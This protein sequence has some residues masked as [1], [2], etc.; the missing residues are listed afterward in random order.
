MQLSNLRLGIFT[1]TDPASALAML[2]SWL[3]FGFLESAF[4]ER[5]PSRYFVFDADT[6]GSR[7]LSTAYIRRYY[8]QWH[9]GFLELPDDKK[10]SLAQSI[11]MPRDWMLFLSVKLG[12]RTPEYNA[13]PLSTAFNATVRTTVLL[14]E[15]L[16]KA[17]PQGFSKVEFIHQQIDLDPGDYIYSRMTERKWCPSS[18]RVLM[19]KYGP[20]VA[21]YATLLEPAENSSVSH[22]GCDRETCVAYNVDVSTYKPR[23]LHE[24][25]SCENIGPP[26]NDVYRALQSGQ[27]PLLDGEGLIYDSPDGQLLVKCYEPGTEFVAVS[28]VWSDG[29]GS[30][31]ENGLPRC[32]VAYLSKLTK[33]ISGS[34]LFWIDGL[35]VP[36]DTNTRIAAIHKMAST[37]GSASI[38]LVLDA[39]IRKCSIERPLEEVIIRILI[40][41]WTRRLWTLQEGA[42]ADRL[43]FLLKDYFL[44][45]KELLSRIFTTNPS[46]PICTAALQELSGYSRKIYAAKPAHIYH[47]QRL[48]VYRTSSRIDDETL[49]IAPLFHVDVKRLTPH[50]GERRIMEFWRCLGKVP[51]G[52]VFSRASKLIA[53][54]FRW[55]PKM[56]MLGDWNVF[57][58]VEGSVTDKGLIG[59]FMLLDLEKQLCLEPKKRYRVLDIIQRKSFLITY[60]SDVQPEKQVQK[61]RLVSDAVAIRLQPNGELVVGP[62]VL[63]IREE[64]VEKDKSEEVEPY[65]YVES[66]SIV[67]DEFVG[68]VAWDNLPD[69]AIIARYATRTIRIS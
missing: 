64:S 46:S 31:T 43:V 11:H 17:V 68:L 6:P 61:H 18:G 65:E 56:L 37:Y 15:L 42:L 38:T 48:I 34:A 27:F 69:D 16:G 62:A 29:L 3:F 22:G 4:L 44:D 20:S 7:V 9:S 28:H 2:Q 19:N 40:S 52:L 49:A 35:C 39:G 33:I 1:D 47:T 51:I 55:A 25:C 54:G 13:L 50:Q 14:T 41:T 53:R 8:Q 23:H 32:Q 58:Y 12:P 67:L 57:S 10:Q 5:F 66:V 30:V 21:M 26:V 60:S 36:K 24:G 59:E 45:L 63:L